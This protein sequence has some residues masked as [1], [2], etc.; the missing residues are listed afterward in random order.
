MAKRYWPNDFLQQR[1]WPTANA[2]YL[3][4]KLYPVGPVKEEVQGK[5]PEIT[6]IDFGL[7]TPYEQLRAGTPSIL[8]V[9]LREPIVEHTLEPESLSSSVPEI[10]SITLKEPIVTTEMAPEALSS[11]QA[12]SISS[13]TINKIVITYADAEAE[14]VESA[15]PQI[16]GIQINET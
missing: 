1:R 10:S 4:S 6:K 2:R 9:S 13:I 14:S 12:P 15:A 8:A 5:P 3:T 11:Q 16:L 7:K